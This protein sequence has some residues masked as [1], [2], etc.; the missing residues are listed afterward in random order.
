MDDIEEIELPKVEPFVAHSIT[1]ELTLSEYQAKTVGKNVWLEQSKVKTFEPWSPTKDK[2]YSE[3]ITIERESGGGKD[4]GTLIH[5]VF[6]KAVQGHDLSNYIKTA[7]NKYNL[8]HDREKEVRSYL[9]SLKTSPLWDELMTAEEVL[10]EV[11]FTL[12]VEKGDLLYSFISKHPENRH[13]YYV[14]GTIDLIYKKNG[15]WTIVDYKTDRAKQVE[16]YEKLQGFYHSQLS[17]YKH[18]WEELTKETVSKEF[19]YFLAPNKIMAT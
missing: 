5:D 19:L 1:E 11:P 14:K 15:T 9:K 10:T 4:W 7:L 16:D 12:K 17:F 8:S 3:V 18:A 6:E 2:D 13:P